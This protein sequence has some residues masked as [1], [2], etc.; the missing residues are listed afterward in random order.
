M[1]IQMGQGEKNLLKI[2]SLTEE[3][4]LRAKIQLLQRT[5]FTSLGLR[6]CGLQ[7]VPLNNMELIELFWALNHQAEAEQGYYPEFPEEFR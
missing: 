6:A 1:E 7:A 2:P 5:E 3:S 4:F